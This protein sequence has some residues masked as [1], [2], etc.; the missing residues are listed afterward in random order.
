MSGV[1]LLAIA[2]DQG[3]LVY[4]SNTVETSIRI[5]STATTCVANSARNPTHLYYVTDGSVAAVDVGRGA[6]TKLW[7]VESN[8]QI[9]RECRWGLFVLGWWFAAYP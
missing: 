5:S 1:D 3:A 9:V 4:D 6:A 7:S 8:E 2:G